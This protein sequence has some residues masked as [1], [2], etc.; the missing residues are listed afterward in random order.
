MPITASVEHSIP[1]TTYANHR[2]RKHE[3]PHLL[4]RHPGTALGSY[5]QAMAASALQ[6]IYGTNAKRPVATLRNVQGIA[7]ITL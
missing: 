1:P 5:W 6:T 3:P 7:V 2:H 4:R